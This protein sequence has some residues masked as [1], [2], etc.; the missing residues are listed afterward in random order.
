MKN[1]PAAPMGRARRPSSV[2]WL[3]SASQVLQRHAVSRQ[4]GEHLG[5]R[6]LIEL[7]NLNFKSER[8]AVLVH[9]EMEKLVS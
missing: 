1:A 6:R 7:G 2:G 8:Q 3:T 4:V 9:R 5:E